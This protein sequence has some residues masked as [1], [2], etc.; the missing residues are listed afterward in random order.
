ML[1][2]WAIWD[3]LYDFT[4]TFNRLVYVSA[5]Y[6]VKRGKDEITGYVQIKDFELDQ[7]K[8]GFRRGAC[9]DGETIRRGKRILEKAS[10]KQR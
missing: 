10:T 6:A 9:L 1:R 8:S 4:H 2:L 3:W 5:P 7:K